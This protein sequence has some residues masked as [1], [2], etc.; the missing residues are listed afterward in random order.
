[1]TVIT[2]KRLYSAHIAAILQLS[3][4]FLQR[5]VNIVITCCQMWKKWVLLLHIDCRGT[6][7]EKMI[8]M[9][10]DKSSKIVKKNLWYVSCPFCFGDIIFHNLAPVMC[11]K[12]REGLANYM[13]L[14]EDIEIRKEY[15]ELGKKWEIWTSDTNDT[16]CI[17]KW[18]YI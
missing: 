18:G 14:I 8:R 17:S 15:Y 2:Q 4:L 11:P 12:C 7:V 13:D 6:K 16:R 3:F 10:Q 9:F 5:Y 1:M